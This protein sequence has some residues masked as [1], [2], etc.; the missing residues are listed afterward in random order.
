MTNTA[1]SFPYLF[2]GR[3]LPKRE[4][5]S[6]TLSTVA[7]L[8]GTALRIWNWDIGVSYAQNGTTR[9]T[10]LAGVRIPA[11]CPVNVN[12]GAANHDPAE[13]PEPDRFDIMRAHPDRHLTFGVG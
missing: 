13:W 3:T 5:A 7:G 11:G 12:V 6:T 9:D 10:D 2:R 1:T 8:R 4:L